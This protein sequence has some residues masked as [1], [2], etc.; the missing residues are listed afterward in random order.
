MMERG[1]NTERTEVAW[2]A[3]LL[4]GL[5]A[6]T[7]ARLA[8]LSLNAT[9][10]FF[11]E[12]QYWSWS[13]EPDF[14]YY[15]KPPL[16]AW[17]IAAST[18]VCGATEFCVRLPSP[19][20]HLGTA[21][22]IFALGARLYGTPVGVLS[23]L[24]FATLPGVSLSSGII[25]TDVPLLF[26]WALA[27]LGFAALRDTARWWP[28]LLLGIAIGL[29][30]NAKY[31]M[32]WFVMCAAIF[33]AATP[34][35]RRLIRDPRVYAA[36]AIA[37]VLIAPNLWW[38]FAHKFAT[39]SHTADN[40]NWR[41]TLPNPLKMLEFVAAQFGV[42]GPILFAV[43]LV[44]AWRAWRYGLPGNDRMLLAFSLP[45]LIVITLQAL[46]SRA[47]A[48][49]AAVSYVAASV[50]VT[51]TLVRDLD[52]SWLRR[53]MLVN[54]AL[55]LLIVA[56]TT[57]AGRFALPSGV[58]PFGRTLGWRAVADATRTEIE[59]ARAAGLPFAAVLSTDRSV[60]AEL[61]YYM[62]SEPTPVRAWRVGAPTDHFELVRPYLGMP[63]GRVLLVSLVP[64]E[65]IGDD[66][67]GRFA[68]MTLLRSIDVS[69][70]AGKPRR[71][72][73]IVL[74]GYKT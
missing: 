14:G 65:R 52:I 60:T 54:V 39:F 32:I 5:A 59:A 41:G 55:M 43:L 35:E 38:N 6:L 29:G 30:L 48:N 71:I 24:A 45:V 63:A 8:A 25:S 46:V 27:L 36:I 10:L 69:A 66:I 51:A 11:D 17:L 56:G 7:A 47:H 12:A 73:F 23:A 22:T 62:R 34:E 64:L 50:L 57:W 21:L 13:T 3:V 33:I 49:W 40:A 26:F 18:S 67:K 58:D 74:E 9:D 20:V 19:I 68:S 31:A 1:P 61:L 42:F 53:S 15:S 28:A 44:V 2:I 70:G 72:S 4:L 37:A 16:I